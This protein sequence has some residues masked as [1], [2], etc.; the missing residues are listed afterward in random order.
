MH[1]AGYVFKNKKN[2]ASLQSESD[3]K[4]GIPEEEMKQYEKL[5]RLYKDYE[6]YDNPLYQKEQN[7]EKSI[8]D[9]L[10][11]TFSIGFE[12]VFE[13]LDTNKDNV[14]STNELQTLLRRKECINT[15]VDD[16]PNI[17]K[18]VFMDGT[19]K[20]IRKYFKNLI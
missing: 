8:Y 2:E 20:L 12:N 7:K 1:C 14:I 9:F 3:I 19:D 13:T 17:I 4:L 15:V 11:Q 16:V 10:N 18:R 5:Q 6:K